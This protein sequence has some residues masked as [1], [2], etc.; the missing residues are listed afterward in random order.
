MTKRRLKARA[1]KYARR[2]GECADRC[3]HAKVAMFLH[4]LDGVCVRLAA[5]SAVWGASE[6]MNHFTKGMV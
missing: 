1:R 2:I 6:W 3:E 5:L 4:N